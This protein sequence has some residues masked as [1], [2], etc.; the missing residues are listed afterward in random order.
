M[1]H[2]E[3]RALTQLVIKV[4]ED[5]AC[6]IMN[7]LHEKLFTSSLL[8]HCGLAF[9]DNCANIRIIRDKASFSCGFRDCSPSDGVSTVAGRNDPQGTVTATIDWLHVC[10]T[11]H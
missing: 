1:E 9:L 8:S 11:T 2:D 10:G 5:Y 7:R 4:N 3:L 6:E